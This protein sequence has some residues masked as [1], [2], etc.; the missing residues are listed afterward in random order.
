MGL[1]FCSGKPILLLLAGIV[2]LCEA[3]SVVIQVAY[4]KKT[5]KRVFKMTPIHHHFEMCNWN[6]EKIVFV[7]SAVALVFGVISV[8]L[9]VFA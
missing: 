2:Y 9:A 4:F 7:F 6:E 3:L 5:R 1:S 8:L